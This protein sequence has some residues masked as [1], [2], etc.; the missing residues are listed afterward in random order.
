MLHF[1]LFRLPRVLDIPNHNVLQMQA[2]NRPLSDTP[3]QL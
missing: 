2:A 3:S 1:K